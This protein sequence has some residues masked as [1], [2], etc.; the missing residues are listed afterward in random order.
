MLSP[1][2][3]HKKPKKTDYCDFIVQPVNMLDQT[4][5]HLQFLTF[6]E[7]ILKKKLEGVSPLLE[8]SVLIYKSA[9]DG[10]ISTLGNMR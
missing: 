9:V 3:H 10:L 5:I 1:G 7:K 6:N 8:E 2:A 4:L